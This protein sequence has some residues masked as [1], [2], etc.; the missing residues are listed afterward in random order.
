[1]AAS[2]GSASPT[3][4]TDESGETS[5]AATCCSTVTAAEPETPPTLAVIVAV[6]F[7]VAVVLPKTLTDATKRSSDSQFTWARVMG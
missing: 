6:P 3:T 7:P 4:S 5:M 1:M 2:R